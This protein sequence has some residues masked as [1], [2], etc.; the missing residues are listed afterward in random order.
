MKS[1]ICAF[2][3]ALAGTHLAAQTPVPPP[4]PIQVMVLGTY[5][6]GN[7]GL[8]LHN[9]KVDSVLTP[10]R[11]AELEDVAAR[12]AKFNPTKI[13]TEALSDRA[14]FGV[15]KFAEFTLQKLTTNPD[16]RVQIA[17]RLAR[18]LDLKT[19]YGI[20]EQSDTIDYFPFDKVETYART[21]G[22]T[23][24]LARLQDGVEQMV[25]Q[26]EAAQ[27]SKP[28]RLMLADQNEPATIQSGHENFYYG[29]LTFGDQ[30]AQPGAELNAGWYQRNAKIFSKLA[31]I[32]RPGDRVLVVFGSGHSFW[33][34]H[35]VQNTPGFELVEPN[36]YLR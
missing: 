4:P 21:H 31:Q 15:N 13:A 32:A 3:A 34:R 5:H 26:M 28:I 1:W 36:Q 33:L 22:Q 18:R 19:V 8:D 29:L 11:Q 23:A 14:D 7:P 30:K 20:D 35:F 2:F 25:K 24:A 17:F 16:E 6:F 10:A 9:M 12:L 27:K